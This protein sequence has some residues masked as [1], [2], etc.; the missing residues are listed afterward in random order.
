MTD[1]FYEEDELNV[2]AHAM[3]HAARYPLNSLSDCEAFHAD[4]WGHVLLGIKNRAQRHERERLAD[5]GGG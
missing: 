2:E 1:S 3:A 4:V 5:G